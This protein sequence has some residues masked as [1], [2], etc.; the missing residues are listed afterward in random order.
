[1]RITV[2]FSSLF[3]ILAGVEREVLDVAEGTTIDRLSSILVQKYQNLP[4]RDEKTYFVIHGQIV[5]RDHVLAEGDKVQ[6]FQLLAG[7]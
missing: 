1:M 5:T 4:L 3:R 6:I 7:G 2:Q